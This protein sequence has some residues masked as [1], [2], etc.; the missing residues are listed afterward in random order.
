M[1]ARTSADGKALRRARGIDIVRVTSTLAI[2]AA[3]RSMRDE[4]SP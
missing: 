2:S 1:F 3:L 4:L